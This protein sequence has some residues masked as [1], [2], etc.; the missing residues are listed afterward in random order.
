ME[1]AGALTGRTGSALPPRSRK[2]ARDVKWRLLRSPL[3]K[4]AAVLVG[5]FTIF[6]GVALAGVLPA[7]VQ[8]AVSHVAG[9]VGI[10]L[11][12]PD[13]DEQATTDD[14]GENGDNQ[15][16]NENSRAVVPQPGPSD[17]NKPPVPGGDE[18]SGD[19]GNQDQQ[20]DN[21]DQGSQDQNAGDQG[22]QDQQGDG[23]GGS[24]DRSG[25]G[26]QGGQGD[27]GGDGGD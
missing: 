6:S 22:N 3:G 8:K 13:E 9:T 15:G 1:A 20:G 2:A 27:G 5:M 18:Q 7:P 14:Q 23:H 4:V 26:D 10:H 17:Q 11:P 24:G 21:N 12:S 19:Q 25:G 16:E